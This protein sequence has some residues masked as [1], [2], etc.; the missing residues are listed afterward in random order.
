MASSRTPGWWMQLIGIAHLAVG[1]VIYR[2]ALLEIA[3]DGVV[4]SV[5]DRGDRATAFWFVIGAPLL[6]LGGR[7]MRSAEASGDLG[8]QRTAGAA[9]AVTGAVGAAA[10]PTSGFWAL[11]ATGV[12][13]V[14]R[15]FR[16]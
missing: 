1:A 14:R 2:D 9:L 16:G 12:A 10:A 6:W 7:L 11:L 8:A 5:P 15:G 13:A 4:D 3:R